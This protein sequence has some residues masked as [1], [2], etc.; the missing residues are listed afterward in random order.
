MNK[1]D[2]I[3]LLILFVGRTKFIVKQIFHSRQGSK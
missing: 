1:R 3:P 2:N